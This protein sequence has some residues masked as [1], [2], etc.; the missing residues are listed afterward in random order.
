MRVWRGVGVEAIGELKHLPNVA[1]CTPHTPTV[2]SNE[3]MQSCNH[4]SMQ[5]CKHASM[6]ACKHASM[7]SGSHL[8]IEAV[9]HEMTGRQRTEGKLAASSD[10]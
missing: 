10:L 9:A 2:L 7:Q 6:Q 4:A 1:C 3:I 5:A 8:P